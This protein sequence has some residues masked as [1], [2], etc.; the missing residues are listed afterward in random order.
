MNEKEI[1]N[2]YAYL[3]QIAHNQLVSFI[4]EKDRRPNINPLEEKHENL[5]QEEI[6]NYRCENFKFRTKELLDCVHKEVKES[7]MYLI[8]ELINVR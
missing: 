4:R 7:E 2:P 6:E 1:H 3:W 8:R 5:A